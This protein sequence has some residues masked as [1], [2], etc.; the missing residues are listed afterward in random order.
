MQHAFSYH[1]RHISY[2]TGFVVSYRDNR[3]VIMTNEHVIAGSYSI[4]VLLSE[5]RFTDAYV[6][7]AGPADLALVELKDV[8]AEFR[9]MIFQE[10]PIPALRSVVYLHGFFPAF[11]GTAILPSSCPGH[12]TGM[13]YRDNEHLLLGDFISEP[14]CSGGP[15]TMGDRVIAVLAGGRHGCR[16][17][18]STLTVYMTLMEWCDFHSPNHTIAGMLRRLC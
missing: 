13:W 1:R 9:P 4:T 18:L 6:K 11:G 5:H 14:G 8:V 7:R 3:C 15:I 17:M 2:G 16:T 10:L 12:I